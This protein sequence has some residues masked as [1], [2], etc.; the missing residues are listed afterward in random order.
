MTLKRVNP[1]KSQFKN[2][3]QNNTFSTIQWVRKSNKEKNVTGNEKK[4]S[5]QYINTAYFL[6]SLGLVQLI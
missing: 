5:M 4:K 1:S 6:Q 3:I 2:L